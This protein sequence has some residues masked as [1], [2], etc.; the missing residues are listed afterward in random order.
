MTTNKELYDSLITDEDE[1]KVSRTPRLDLKQKLKLYR[2]QAITAAKDLSYGNVVV[3]NIKNATS[4]GEIERI[5]IT[6]R[7]NMKDRGIYDD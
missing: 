6:A 4:V 3:N 7:K 2:K 5:L 1:N